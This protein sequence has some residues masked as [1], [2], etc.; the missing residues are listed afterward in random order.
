[1]SR[2]VVGFTE[3]ID[4]MPT[5]DLRRTVADVLCG[6]DPIA[7]LWCADQAL[8]RG[9]LRADVHACLSFG[10][11]GVR[12]A[13]RLLAVADARSES[14]LESAVALALDAAGLPRPARQLEIIAPGGQLMRVDFAWPDQRIVLEADGVAFH[15]SAPALLHDR[16]RQNALMVLGWRTVRCVWGDLSVDPPPFIAAVQALL[17]PPRTTSRP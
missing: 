1:M 4:G 11:R 3:V 17:L 6:S 9:M 14:P 5:T 2:S 8:A 13:R 16:R 10:Q 15:S 12:T 7:Q